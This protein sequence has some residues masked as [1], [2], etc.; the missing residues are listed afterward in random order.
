MQLKLVEVNELSLA[1]VA[2]VLELALM[3]VQMFS[4]ARFSLELFIAVRLGA[5][6]K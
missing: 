1:L 3:K 2:L 4:E 6:E 5:C